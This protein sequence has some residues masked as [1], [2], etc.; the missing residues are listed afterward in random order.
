MAYGVN[1]LYEDSYT[2]QYDWERYLQP[3]ILNFHDLIYKEFN[4][5]V[6]LQMGTLLPFVAS[7][8]GPKTKGLWSTRPNVLNFFTINIATSG[9]GKSQARKRLISEPLKYIL[10][11]VENKDKFP[12]M[13]VNKFTRAGKIIQLYDI[14]NYS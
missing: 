11:H 12:D 1:Q 10:Q 3:E 14:I 4:S 9:T 5:P 8:A 13:E 6:A 7:L 2:M